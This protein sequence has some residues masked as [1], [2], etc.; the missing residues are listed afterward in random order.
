MAFENLPDTHPLM[1][2]EGLTAPAPG[3][4][5]VSR[6][7]EG[8]MSDGEESAFE[9]L[10]QE[11][12]SLQ[13][14]VE[15]EQRELERVMTPA[16]RNRLWIGLQR[17]LGRTE[18]RRLEPNH[19]ELLRPRGA[20][21]WSWA[22]ASSALKTAKSSFQAMTEVPA[23]FAELTDAWHRAMAGADEGRLAFLVA[24]A[25]VEAN[26]WLN[27]CH[28]LARREIEW[29]EADKISRLLAGWRR[30]L[31]S[32]PGEWSNRWLE[33]LAEA[34]SLA[35]QISG[36][37]TVPEE[38]AAEMR[39]PDLGGEVLAEAI[40]A[41]LRSDTP[42]AANF[43]DAN[44]P[45]L[46]GELSVPVVM[47]DQAGGTHGFLRLYLLAD[48]SGEIRPT[49]RMSMVPMDEPFALAAQKAL[50][51]LKSCGLRLTGF[52][53][54]WEVRPKDGSPGLYCGSSL[55]MSLA[56]GMARLIGFYVPET[57]VR[58]QI[59]DDLMAVGSFYRFVCSGSL[60]PTQ[61]LDDVEAKVRAVL[62][63]PEVTL[64]LL[65]ASAR[66]TMDGRWGEYRSHHHGATYLLPRRQG[67]AERMAVV[68]CSNLVEMVEAIRV[69]T[70]I[71]TVFWDWRTEAGRESPAP[72]LLLNREWLYT[73]IADHHREGT[74]PFLVLA[75][76]S[77]VGKSGAVLHY[78]HSLS[79]GSAEAPIV[80]I[81]KSDSTS[82]R[83]NPALWLG[84]LSAQL[85]RKHRLAAPSLPPQLE[86]WDAND[87]HREA[88]RL[89]ASL[90]ELYAKGVVETLFIDGLDKTYKLGGAYANGS[91]ILEL[92]DGLRRLELISSDSQHL[93]GPAT[94][95]PAPQTPV[96]I[97]MILT[98]SL[99]AKIAATGAADTPH[100]S[101]GD[102]IHNLINPRLSTLEEMHL[103]DPHTLALSPELEEEFIAI[104]LK[105]GLNLEETLGV[106]SELSKS[107]TV[108]NV[109]ERIDDACR[110][111]ANNLSTAVRTFFERELYSAAARLAGGV[112]SGPRFK[113]ALANLI[114]RLGLLAS[115]RNP[116][117]LAMLRSMLGEE[118]TRQTVD[119]LIGCRGEF[120]MGDL[121]PGGDGSL[122]F[123]SEGFRAFVLDL[124]RLS[125]A[126][127]PPNLGDAVASLIAANTGK[128]LSMIWNEF[129]AT[130][131]KEIWR[132]E[133]ADAPESVSR[134]VVRHWLAHLRRSGDWDCLI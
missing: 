42:D 102:H 68:L 94:D 43:A 124:G 23:N 64:L 129:L 120:V 128:D 20:A 28:R 133:S 91:A 14:E 90:S 62:K 100:A 67:S 99:D 61:R 132:G 40:T 27:L 85:R 56:I 4:D 11:D 81:N 101:P 66:E 119:C 38:L 12:A 30:A 77:G 76:P 55:T 125:P 53:I 121:L 60:D 31:Y 17:G 49:V 88:Q 33:A 110:W 32:Q 15:T 114:D 57:S 105:R 18:V 1:N 51:L 72:S 7:L 47:V 22:Q 107:T 87:V 83:N 126:A 9:E 113:K 69:E 34:L 8:D 63:D 84:S 58:R 123:C 44:G 117:T 131:C 115:A 116:L 79:G 74:L 6:Y 48:G 29:P 80:H 82:S 5:L 71:P 37:E 130:A 13:R 25:D 39:D 92:V 86:A 24:L 59:C 95:A 3:E 106:M 103:W 108:G 134:Y 16:L 45:R 112:K 97:R 75:G 70:D 26:V 54:S 35:L 10:M 21:P 78:L 46:K 96:R 19:Q 2:L 127:L 104:A 50:D 122:E 118:Y 111:K 52:D 89:A 73:T 41:A 109:I 65:D 36:C 98:T 93:D